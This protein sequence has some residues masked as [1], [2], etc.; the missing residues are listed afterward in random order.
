MS[1]RDALLTVA[2]VAAWLNVDSRFV[3]RL[4]GAGEL[5]KTYVGR[6]LRVPESSVAAYLKAR[7]VKAAPRPSRARRPG[8]RARRLRAVNDGE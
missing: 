7:T 8:A 2:E 5:D 6:Y 1:D 3:Y 4:T